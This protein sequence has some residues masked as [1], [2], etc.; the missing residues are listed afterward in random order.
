M[1][2]WIQEVVALLL[3]L[4]RQ[5][6]QLA[7]EILWAIKQIEKNPTLTGTLILNTRYCY[8]DPKGRFRISYNYQHPAHEIEIVVLNVNN[9]NL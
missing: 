7:K 4:T 2:N 9:E 3:K 6:P 1:A 8:T 5:N